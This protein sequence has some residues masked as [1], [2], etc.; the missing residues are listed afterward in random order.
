MR[1]RFILVSPV[2]TTSP[3]PTLSS[4]RANH[5]RTLT[6]GRGH[7]HCGIIC[8]LKKQVRIGLV[9]R[10][11]VQP[12]IS[13]RARVAHGTQISPDRQALQDAVSGRSA[14]CCLHRRGE[15]D[16]P[17]VNASCDVGLAGFAERILA[18][19]S[20]AARPSVRRPNRNPLRMNG[21]RFRVAEIAS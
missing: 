15:P 10:G 14:R 17:L 1:I 9:L 8:E 5:P 4:N 21:I 18:P 16:Q 20:P 2:S 3:I 11:E 13:D 6:E 12:A 19:L 7:T